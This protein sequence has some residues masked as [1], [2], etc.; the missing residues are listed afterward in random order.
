MTNKPTVF[1]TK[2][3]H[4]VFQFPAKLIEKM[5]KMSKNMQFLNFF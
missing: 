1:N 2:K 5:M 3:F 4:F